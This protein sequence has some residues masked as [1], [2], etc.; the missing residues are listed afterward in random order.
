MRNFIKHRQLYHHLKQRRAALQRDMPP[1]GTPATNR[2]RVIAQID[3]LIQQV[4]ALPGRL[5]PAPGAR[6]DP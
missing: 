6:P 5:R 1:D 3:G 4:K 2:R